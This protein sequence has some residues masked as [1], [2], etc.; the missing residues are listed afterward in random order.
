MRFQAVT[1]KLSTLLVAEPTP[2]AQTFPGHS[3]GKRKAIEEPK[4]FDL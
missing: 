1:A 3:A 2:K 4:R